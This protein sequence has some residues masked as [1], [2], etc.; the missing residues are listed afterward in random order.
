[1]VGAV[2]WQATKGICLIGIFFFS[3][4]LVGS[5]QSLKE[6]GAVA[7]LGLGVAARYIAADL[8]HGN[9][10]LFVCFLVV[11]GIYAFARNKDILSG[12]LLGLATAVK[13][14]PALLIVY[15]LYKRQ[16]KVVLASAVGVVVFL[17]IIPVLAQGPTAAWGQFSHWWN[18]YI[19]PY[20]VHG[21]VFSKQ[22]NQSLPGLLYRLTVNSPAIDQS[23]VRINL[24]ELTH[25]QA[26]WLLRLL[27]AGILVG[28]G[29]ALRGRIICRGGLKQAAEY[30]LVLLAMLI[31]SERSWKA[32]YVTTVLAAVV[33][34]AALWAKGFGRAEHRVLAGLLGGAAIIS[35]GTASDLIGSVASNYAEAHGAVLST[36][37]LLVVAL[38]LIHGRNIKDQNANIKTTY[39][40]S[41]S[42]RLST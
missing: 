16:W 21:E 1:M 17:V 23:D 3:L 22:I 25:E 18:G 42:S 11:G 12:L 26:R 27:T 14:T 39:Q 37:F 8:T 2:I 32:H 13:V 4:R 41:K 28:L 40:N 10:N 6:L 36:N 34:A 24:L 9:I 29:Y 30:G 20:V 33:V 35:W 31:L 5:T 38:L 15:F 19:R 7:L